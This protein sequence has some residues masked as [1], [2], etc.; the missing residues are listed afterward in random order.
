MENIGKRIKSLR[1]GRGYSLRKLGDKINIAFTHLSNIENGI[2]LPTLETVY[3][4]ADY[5]D[6]S[7]SSLIDPELTDGEKNFMKDL[8]LTD[9]ELI[10]KYN[11]TID[12]K[13]PTATELKM[14]ISMIR[15]F[16]ETTKGD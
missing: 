7:P 8:E 16:R 12:G 1:I 3:A 5:F 9:E 14:M 10:D 13:A 4:I 15:S 6:V 11:L 2:K